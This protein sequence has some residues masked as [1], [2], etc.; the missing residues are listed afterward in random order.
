MLFSRCN[1]E[2]AG[3]AITEN[4][5][6]VNGG[7]IYSDQGTR[8]TTYT[9][10]TISG[11]EARQGGGL[12]QTGGSAPNFLTCTFLD[13]HARFQGGGVWC[14]GSA[15]DF[16][17]CV[18]RGNSS[19]DNGG[20]FFSK[21]S[22]PLLENCTVVGNTA[23]SGG[24]F[25]TQGLYHNPLIVNSILWNNSPDEIFVYTGQITVSFSDVQEAWDGEGNIDIPPLFVDYP[26]GDLHLQE[27]SPCV[28]AADPAS[29]V[30]PGGGCVIDMGA[31]EL[32][33]GFNCRKDRDSAQF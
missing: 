19:V 12:Y 8:P 18:F 25:Y 23:A 3:C 13:N 16:Q 21:G 2:I 15:P 7:G 27:D 31:F 33:K 22:D 6:G 24:G 32:W 26:A 17:N 20:A 4:E 10:C 1:A 5:C 9:D 14:G 28:D 30:P 29:D 11:N